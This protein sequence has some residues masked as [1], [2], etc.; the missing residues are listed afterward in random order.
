[1]NRLR[2]LGRALLRTGRARTPLDNIQDGAAYI[3]RTYG[4][5]DI[6]DQYH[7]GW[8]AR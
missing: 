1:V 5:Q 7:R 4:D 2:R 3:R 6:S 8:V